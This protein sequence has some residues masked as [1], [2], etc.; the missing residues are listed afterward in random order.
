MRRLT[1]TLLN[2][3]SLINH[4]CVSDSGELATRSSR[5]SGSIESD[6]RSV[7]RMVWR[8]HH[9]PR[10]LCRSLLRICLASL[11]AAKT[12]FKTIASKMIQ[13][14]A[15]MIERIKPRR[16]V[17]ELS[18]QTRLSGAAVPSRAATPNRTVRMAWR[19]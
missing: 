14:P 2:D 16:R 1:R 17:I 19:G 4:Q 3:C 11:L 12:E 9:R 8:R 5:N 6:L 13:H 15:V 7:P 10:A 18:V